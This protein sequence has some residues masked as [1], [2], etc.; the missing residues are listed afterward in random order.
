LRCQSKRIAANSSTLFDPIPAPP[1]RDEPQTRPT[2]RLA[3]AVVPH[4]AR[5]VAPAP[6]QAG[7]NQSA[8]PQPALDGA[9]SAMGGF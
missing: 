8:T 4:P 1:K 9:K 5:R 2:I 3:R 7:P 6:K